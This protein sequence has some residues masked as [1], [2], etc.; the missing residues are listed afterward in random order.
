MAPHTRFL[1]FLALISYSALLIW[2]VLWHFVLAPSEM[3]SPLFLVLMWVLPGLLPLKGIIQGKPYTHAW[4]NFIL[5][6]YILHG[7]T[8]VYAV[9]EQWHYA[10]VEIL[11]SLS[12]FIGCTYYARYRGREL[13]IGLKKRKS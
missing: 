5:M 11:L 7:F 6:I 1:R 2:V 9:S 8:S 10:T 3:Y 4:A 12:A 13:G